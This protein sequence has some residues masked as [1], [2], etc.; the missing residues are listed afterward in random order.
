MP[1][2]PPPTDTTKATLIAHT[3]WIIAV[4]P[5][6]FLVVVSTFPSHDW[7]LR[8]ALTVGLGWAGGVLVGAIARALMDAT[9]A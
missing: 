3:T 5:L 6:V 2:R 7:S 4:F 8:D 9:D 1:E